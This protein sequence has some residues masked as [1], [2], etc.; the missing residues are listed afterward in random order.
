MNIKEKDYSLLQIVQNIIGEFIQRDEIL[1]KMKE[2]FR[3]KQI[4]KPSMSNEIILKYTQGKY[5]LLYALLKNG[6]SF[7]MAYR[8]INEYLKES[9]KEDEQKISF[10]YELAENDDKN[11]DLLNQALSILYSYPELNEEI[12]FNKDNEE[13]NDNNKSNKKANKS[14]SF[15]ASD[16]SIT[17]KDDKKSVKSDNKSK[18]EEQLNDSKKSRSKSGSQS[19]IS[20]KSSSSGQSSSIS[21]GSEDSK[22]SD[23]S[24]SISKKI[25]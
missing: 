3:V 1:P 20:G 5:L 4:S 13:K 15:S 18:K 9:I 14:G 12:S 6:F 16:K 10:F 17:S 24:R 25:R 2:S 21:K 8:D 11:N 22:A 23:K 7:S 19:N